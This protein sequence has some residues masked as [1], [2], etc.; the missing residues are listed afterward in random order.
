MRADIH[1]SALYPSLLRGSEFLEMVCA[2]AGRR[3]AV[4]GFEV[5]TELIMKKSVFWDI[6]SCSPLKFKRRFGGTY[7]IDFKVK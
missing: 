4:L 6:T 3:I 5:L 7:R 1:E 2:L